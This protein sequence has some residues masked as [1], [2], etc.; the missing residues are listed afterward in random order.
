MDGKTTVRLV[1]V[2]KLSLIYHCLLQ[3]YNAKEA[4][5]GKAKGK[6]VRIKTYA[7]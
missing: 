2:F 1:L 4:E 5:A 7:L 6:Q 3:I